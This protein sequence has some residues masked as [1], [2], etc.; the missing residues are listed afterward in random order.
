M[1]SGRWTRKPKI[2]LILYFNKKLQLTWKVKRRRPIRS[3]PLVVNVSFWQLS[4]WAGSIIWIERCGGSLITVILSFPRGVAF[5]PDSL[6]AS[7]LDLCSWVVLLIIALI[8]EFVS[9]LPCLMVYR[10]H[11]HIWNSTYTENWM[12]ESKDIVQ[13][14]RRNGWN[15]G[16]SAHW[17]FKLISLASL[18]I[19]NQRVPC[20]S[21][22][23]QFWFLMIDVTKFC[24]Y[25]T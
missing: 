1:S 18:R 16:Q 23:I 22:D 14:V 11:F 15:F 3:S 21:I 20:V 24:M 17:P 4:T 2:N 19:E 12:H 13:N 7:W 10:I 25:I 6:A 5:D 9:L 8:P